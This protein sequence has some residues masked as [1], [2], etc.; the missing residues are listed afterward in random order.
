[1]DRIY[2]NIEPEIN[3][4]AV[5]RVQ[6]AINQLQDGQEIMI[7][8]EAADA[9][10]AGPVIELLEQAGLDYQSRGSHEGRTYFL[11]GRRKPH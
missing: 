11:I 7:T 4:R 9:H 6:E 10:Q 3:S 1:M 5:S 2:V 8:M